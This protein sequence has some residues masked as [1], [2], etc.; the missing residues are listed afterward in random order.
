MSTSHGRRIRAVP[1][2][3]PSF[4]PVS[5]KVASVLACAA[6]TASYL[7]WAVA[8][9]RGYFEL[10]EIK[11]ASNGTEY[12]QL[13]VMARYSAFTAWYAVTAASLCL[14]ALV[15][16]IW[17]QAET[18]KWL[19]RL[20][21][22]TWL[23]TWAF[24]IFGIVSF[25]SSD[26][27]LAAGCERGDECWQIRQGLQVGLVIAVFATLA[28]VFYCA[29]ILSSY[30]HTLHPHLFIS[31]DSDSDDEYSDVEEHR[32][33]ELEEELMRSGHPYAG[34]A[35]KLL[36]HERKQLAAERS[37]S[38]RRSGYTP[39]KDDDELPLAPA[40]S[41]RV[42]APRRA[43]REYSS[44]ESEG[45]SASHSGS[46]DEERAVLVGAGGSGRP[47]ATAGMTTSRGRPP[48]RAGSARQLSD[49]S[50]SGVES[51][52]GTE[53][54]GPAQSAREMGRRRSSSV[55]RSRSR[56]RRV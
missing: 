35:L 17:P 23:A 11:A 46:S 38:R 51:A 30:V 16:S 25:L 52:S 31:P 56:S 19:S 34:D 14:G 18:A 47:K 5:T 9:W 45:S 55:S 42:A 41:S 53:S 39:E 26:A 27:F 1:L 40:S 43:P 21:W 24:G 50:S 48:A 7:A 10:S 54:E 28:V 2:P 49:I 4:V 13:V 36:H 20:I 15:V 12:D 37:M 6:M 32:A 44:S 33:Q 22:M 3:C 29:I 8:L